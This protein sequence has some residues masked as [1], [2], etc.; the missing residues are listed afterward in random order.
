MVPAVYVL[1]E[2]LPLTA[3]G[4][5]DRRGLPAPSGERPEQGQGY[6]G[7]RTAA[8]E[9]LAG[10]WAKGLGL[11]RVGVEDNFFE[12]GGD[13]IL[14]LQIV[15]RAREA[16]LQITVP[17]MF[18]YQSIAALVEQVQPVVS[19]E[20]ADVEDGPA[21]GAVPLTPI[22][23]WF[24]EQR[25]EEPW[26]WNQSVLLKVP[27]EVGPEI[28]EVAL[29]Q[30]LVH[31][32]ALRLRFVQGGDG[33]WQQGYADWEGG[34][35][36]LEQMDLSHLPEEARRSALTREGDRLQGSLNLG[37]GPVWRAGWIDLGSGERRLLLVVHHLVVDGV[38]WRILLEDLQTLCRQ[39][40]EGEPLQLPLRT[41]SFGQWG[42]A[43]ARYA[44]SDAMQA[45]IAYWEG[46][47]VYPV[48]P[49]R[50][51]ADVE[52]VENTAGSTAVVHLQL[53][54]E[55]TQ[56]LLLEVPRAYRTRIQEVLVTALVRGLERW[57]GQRGVLL[58]LEG[59]G[60]EE[61]EVSTKLDLSRTVGWF[62]TLYPVY[63][64]LTGGG[65]GE[66]LKQIKEQLRAVPGRGLGFGVLRYLRGE[67]RNRLQAV[68]SAEVVFNYL[69]QFDQVLSEGDWEVAPEPAG[70]QC[71]PVERRT[72]LLEINSQI[73]GGCLHLS[74]GYSRVVQGEE[75]IRTLATGCLDELRGLIAHCRTAEGSFTPSDFPL[76]RLTQAE[77]DRIG[78][79]RELG[80]IYPL[81]P[82]QQGILFHTLEAPGAGVYVNQLCAELEGELNGDAFRR[83]WGEVV[84]RHA[85]LR[86]SFEWEGVTEPVQV[87]EQQA[88]VEWDEQDWRGFGEREQAERL[89]TYLAADRTRGFDLGRAPLMRVGL[90]RTGEGDFQLV[91]SHHHLLLDGWSVPMVLS[92]V[93][94]FY[95]GYCTGEAVQLPRTR[96]YAD[97]IGWLQ[98]QD[99]RTA[100]GFWRELLQGFR[101]PTRLGLERGGTSSEAGGGFDRRGVRLRREVT[102]SLERL[103]QRHRLTLNTLVQGVWGLLL[104]RYSGQQDIV[105]GATTAGRPVD[106]PGVEAMVG[107]FINTLPVRLQLGA[108]D[109]V[110]ECLQRLQSQQSEA[111]RYEY[112]PLSHIQG[113]SEVPRGGPLS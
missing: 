108:G 96:P 67:G 49:L 91:W 14:S 19:G 40:K 82:M 71:S 24:F 45:E 85:V 74:W 48:R 3:N 5:V 68:P 38:S 51:D 44:G 56:A 72:H 31:H 17:Q 78:V 112:T 1:L 105:F 87:V 58:D 47:A 88:E 15:A 61:A 33:V 93:L 77:L 34:T 81:S 43:L 42:E 65:L 29:Q 64:Q 90:L 80:N 70:A 28:I 9:I 113:W 60:R 7:P 53:S 102:E 18:R 39:V 55:E 73:S 6:V 57:S 86:T 97:Y 100:E 2:R 36:V 69:G 52:G 37:A 30:L 16:G 79:G 99:L 106:L 103:R 8:E 109:T 107:L 104:S 92:E 111:R 54:V 13:S 22:Q 98:R 41:S 12:L 32:D 27:R 89:Q 11:D 76:A 46:L 75:A 50:R 4:K 35:R 94:R 23:H 101:S 20:R 95:E 63:V 59:H 110:L 26:H 62:T 66:D 10:I 84:R 21:C 25:L 83:A